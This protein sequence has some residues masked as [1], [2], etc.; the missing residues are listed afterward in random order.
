[1]QTTAGPRTAH[2]HQGGFHFVG[3]LVNVFDRNNVASHFDK[4]LDPLKDCLEEQVGMP[5]DDNNDRPP[6]RDSECLGF[7]ILDE[8]PAFDHLADFSRGQR[9]DVGR[10]LRTT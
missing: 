9:D 5:F 6:L 1:V 3:V 2:H 7:L 4:H 10:T 8:V